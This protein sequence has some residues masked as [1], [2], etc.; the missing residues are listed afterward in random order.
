MPSDYRKVI[1]LGTDKEL[2]LLRHAVLRSAGFEVHTAD[3]EKKALAL[4]RGGPCGVLLLCYSLPYETRERLSEAFRECCPSNRIVAIANQKVEKPEFADALV[5]GV[6]GP[7]ALIEA[8][9]NP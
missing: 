8:L 1:S 7:E 6:E 4:V 5:Y 3:D 9:G 2:L